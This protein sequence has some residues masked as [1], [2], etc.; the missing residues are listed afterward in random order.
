MSPPAIAAPLRVLLV[1]DAPELRMMLRAM[2]GDDVDV[3]EAGCGEE[4]VEV[5]ARERPDVVVID[6]N[7]PGISGVATTRELKALDADVVIAAFTAVPG[8]EREFAAAGACEHFLKDRFGDLVAF[9]QDLV[10]RRGAPP[11]P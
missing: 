9:I 11:S 6:Q 1:D 8:A 4:A 5:A 3:L 7:M 2:L 10:V